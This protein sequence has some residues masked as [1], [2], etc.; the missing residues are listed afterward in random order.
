MTML[1]R[2]NPMKSLARGDTADFDDL[3][4]TFGLRPMFRDLDVAPEIRIDVN[5]SEE[6]YDIDADLPGVRKEDI[7]VTVDGNQVSITAEARRESE[8]KNGGREVRT[9]R[10]Y[11]RVFRSFSLPT[12][13][14]DAKANARYENGV[15]SLHLPKKEDGHQR[16]IKVG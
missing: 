5:E 9:E 14:D 6:A 13:V 12:D 4:R 7:D 15:L 8:R 1:A 11:G 16:R 2:W 10:Y 3:F